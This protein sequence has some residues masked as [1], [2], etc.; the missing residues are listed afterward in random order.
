M[1][2]DAPVRAGA[3]GGDELAALQR[4][5]A[6]IE[7]WP[8]G[9]HR[10]GHYA[11]RTAGGTAICRTENVSACHPGIAAVVHGPLAAL[12]AAAAGTEVVDF[13]DK[14]NYKQPGGA[15]FAPHQD[16]PAYP[17]AT[18]VVSI[19]LA[20]DECSTASGCLWLASGVDEV[21]PTDEGGVVSDEVVAGLDWA[22]VELAPGDA[23]CIDGLAPHY[24]EANRSG[25]PR[26]VLV[27]SFAPAGGGYARASYYAARERQMH[28]AS[29]RDQRFRISTLADFEGVEVPVDRSGDAAEGCW[30]P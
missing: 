2:S 24:S 16:L 7:C 29:A 10:W 14:I 27:A 8:A 9:S 3:V 22:P 30:H 18:R 19:L 25:A 23:L 20:V 26:R 15:G 17:G 11:E 12:A 13:K 6:E 28:A 1:S 5:V 21:L 4:W